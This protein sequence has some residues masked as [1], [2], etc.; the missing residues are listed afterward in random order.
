MEF[1]IGGV[2]WFRNWWTFWGLKNID[3]FD[4]SLKMK[5]LSIL[6]VLNRRFRT[7]FNRIKYISLFFFFFFGETFLHFVSVWSNFKLH[8]TS[9]VC[10]SFV[11][12]S[13][14][15]AILYLDSFNLSQS[16]LYQ[17]RQQIK[18]SSS[19]RNHLLNYGWSASCFVSSAHGL[20]PVH[21]GSCLGYAACIVFAGRWSFYQIN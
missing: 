12:N 20:R 13:V 21:R 5:D 11:G 18:H 17:H 19:I 6:N 15:A 10:S 16:L 14:L 1:G 3:N 4:I 7:V 9:Q 8:L 2:S